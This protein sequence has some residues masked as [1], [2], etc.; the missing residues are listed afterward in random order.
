M[1]VTQAA[2]Q[3]EQA[4]GHGDNSIIQQDVAS[5][6]ETG[7]SNETM[8]ALVWQGKGKVEIG[9]SPLVTIHPR[10]FLTPYS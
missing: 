1:S 10:I 2:H 9:Q 4:I 6:K 3:V 8:K 5:Y 7:E